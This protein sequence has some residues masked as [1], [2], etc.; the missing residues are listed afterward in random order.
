MFAEFED[1]RDKDGFLK[2]EECPQRFFSKLAFEKHSSTQHNQEIET[3]LEQLPRLPL[4]KYLNAC[5]LCLNTVHK[6]H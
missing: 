4:V 3:K 2:C 1:S 6:T 5:F